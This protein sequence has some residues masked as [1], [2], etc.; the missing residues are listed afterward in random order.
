MALLHAGKYQYL[1]RKGGGI[2][3]GKI[4][5]RAGTLKLRGKFSGKGNVLWSILEYAVE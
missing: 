4:T 1:P 5:A 2:F 3:D